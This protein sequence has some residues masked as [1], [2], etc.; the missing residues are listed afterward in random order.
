MKGVDEIASTRD[1]KELY[2]RMDALSDAD[3]DEISL[4]ATLIGEVIAACE[5][6]GAKQSA[7]ALMEEQELSITAIL[8]IL[9]P[10][11]KTLAVVP[12][13]KN[14]GGGQRITP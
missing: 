2:H 8:K 1:W 11:G 13:A 10:L 5:S 14:P 9:R 12:L 3:R 7:V 4:K 6:A